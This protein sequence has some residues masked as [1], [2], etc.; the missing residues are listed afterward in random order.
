MH[1]QVYALCERPSVVHLVEMPPCLETL[2]ILIVTATLTAVRADE[3]DDV[4]G[5]RM[6][7]DTL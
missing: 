4:K 1:T 7:Y 6:R 5:I 2:R 3:D